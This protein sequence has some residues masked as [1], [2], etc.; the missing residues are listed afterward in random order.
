MITL[1]NG[2]VK[3]GERSD[4]GIVDSETGFGMGASLLTCPLCT[5]GCRGVW[6][7]ALDPSQALQVGLTDQGWRPTHG[8]SVHTVLRS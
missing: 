6:P 2:Y 7:A 1:H 8:D 5:Q 4:G 3:G